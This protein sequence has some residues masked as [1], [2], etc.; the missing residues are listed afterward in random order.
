MKVF[1]VDELI[2]EYGD[3]PL[4][5]EGDKQ[6]PEIDENRYE[7]SSCSMCVF[8]ANDPG[9]GGRCEYHNPAVDLHPYARATEKLY[10]RTC[11]YFMSRKRA[12]TLLRASIHERDFVITEDMSW[13]PNPFLK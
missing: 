6:E 4:F 5:P 12:L 7:C 1:D 9:F 13:K 11:P 8:Y 3:Q 2:K 10:N